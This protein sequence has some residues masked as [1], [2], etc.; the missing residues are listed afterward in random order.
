MFSQ[1]PLGSIEQVVIDQK[2]GQEFFPAADLQLLG[3]A[4]EKL[5]VLEGVP[6]AAVFRETILEARNA[7]KQTEASLATIEARHR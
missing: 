5:M 7:R 3:K 2:P 1:V 4:G 6:Y